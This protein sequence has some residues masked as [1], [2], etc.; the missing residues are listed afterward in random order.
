MLLSPSNMKAFVISM[1]ATARKA[2]D[3]ERSKSKTGGVEF[4]YRV[5]IKKWS[6]D[7]DLEFT[8]IVE[9]NN[10]KTGFFNWV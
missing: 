3:F 4:R 10:I 7:K 5:I 1:L 8:G 9:N 6:A 2:N